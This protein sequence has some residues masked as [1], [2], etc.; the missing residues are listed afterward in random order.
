MRQD[1]KALLEKLSRQ[2]FQ[3]RQ[4]EDQYADMELWP[5]FEALLK[6]PR[7]VPPLKTPLG[8]REA[9][10]A[11]IADR[12]SAP[13]NRINPAN[14]NIFAGYGDAEAPQAQARVQ[15]KVGGAD[16][17]RLFLSGLSN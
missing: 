12:P 14:S 6:D 4:F 17:L 7:I 5:I 10:R 9:I 3:Y 11:D 2:D 16:D 8:Q 15:Q 13:P 1:A